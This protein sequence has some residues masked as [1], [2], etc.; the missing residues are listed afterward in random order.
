MATMPDKTDAACNLPEAPDRH[1]AT[2]E[3]LS[4]QYIARSVSALPGIFSEI[5]ALP[6]GAIVTE[7]A[8]ANLFQRHPASIKRAVSRGELPAPARL[9]GG[10]AWTAG[11]IVKHVEKRMEIASK[12]AGKIARRLNDLRP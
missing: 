5:G 12:D 9:L 6:P 3:G 11:A 10:N 1:P 2:S 4:D 8:L 7:D